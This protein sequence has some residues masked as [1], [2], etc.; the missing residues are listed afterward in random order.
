MWQLTITGQP[1]M[2]FLFIQHEQCL[3]SD[4][5]RIQTQ[6]CQ[7]CWKAAQKDGVLLNA[8][9]SPSWQISLVPKWEKEG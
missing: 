9:F 2:F 7:N 6:P 5:Q 4:P 8:C 3:V 1:P